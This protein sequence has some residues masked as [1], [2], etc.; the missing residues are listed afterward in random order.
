LASCT[1][2]LRGRGK[3]EGWRFGK[4]PFPHNSLRLFGRFLLRGGITKTA[5]Q[6]PATFGIGVLAHNVAS[7]PLRSLAAWRAL[8]LPPFS[9]EEGDHLEGLPLPPF[10]EGSRLLPLT[11]L[12]AHASQGLDQ[13]CSAILK[14]FDY[15]VRRFLA[16][17]PIGHLLPP[18]S[19]RWWNLS[20]DG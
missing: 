15:W 17:L 8:A 10:Q 7:A 12:R 20:V 3:R 9:A 2:P 6:D 14:G 18:T 5:D 11:T 19:G 13:R 16:S 1:R 4:R